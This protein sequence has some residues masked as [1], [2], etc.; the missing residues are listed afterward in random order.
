M[1]CSCPK[2]HANIEVDQYKIP[3]K[4][5]FMPCPECKG[6]FWIAREAYA[7]MALNKEGSI[8]C[9]HCGKELDHKI[10]CSACGVMYPDYLLVQLTKPPRRQIEKRDLFSSSFSLKPAQPTYAYNYSYASTETKEPRTT[11]MRPY[12][13]LA[14]VAVIV[15]LIAIGLSS[16]YNK[17]KSD[18]LYVKNYMRALYIIKTGN[19]LSLNICSKISKDWQSSISSRQN[20]I[21]RLNDEDESKLN[22]IKESAERF[23]QILKDPP[24][25]YKVSKEK[26][27]NLY[28][29]YLKVNTLAI[30]P[31]G[32]LSGFTSMVNN[33]QKDFNSGM[34]EVVQSFTSELSAEFQIAKTKYKGFKES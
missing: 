17:K 7:R 5:T 23:M 15:I 25:K 11:E 22:S 33:S 28:D 29:L 20:S 13:K 26:L 8:Y 3:E 12:L 18:Q 9:D 2:C 16:L 27:S 10:I 21:P 24:K 30:A 6:R 1:T 19:D 14:G 4:G 31:S 34:Q 32:S